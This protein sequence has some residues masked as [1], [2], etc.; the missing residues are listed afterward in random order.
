MGGRKKKKQL[1]RTAYLT[2]NKI[3]SS[4]ARVE[5]DC[6]QLKQSGGAE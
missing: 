4:N 6:Q 2:V 1:P 5:I 3:I